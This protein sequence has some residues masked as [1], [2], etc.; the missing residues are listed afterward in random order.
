M[1]ARQTPDRERKVPVR[2]REVLA[3]KGD[4]GVPVEIAVAVTIE[5]AGWEHEPRERPLGLFSVIGRKRNFAEP[6]FDSRK[7][8]ERALERVN[9]AEKAEAASDPAQ[10]FLEAHPPQFL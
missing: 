2:A 5:R 3:P 4:A 1:Q 8:P 6:V 10:R 9:C 7:L